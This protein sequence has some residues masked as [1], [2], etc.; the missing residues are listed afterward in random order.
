MLF[1]IGLIFFQQS[2]QVYL[3]KSY[4]HTGI[5]FTVNEELVSPI[6]VI[7]NFDDYKFVDIGWG[8]EEFYQHPNPD[9]LLG[10]QAILVPTSSVIRI[11]GKNSSIDRIIE[12]SDFCIRFDLNNEQFTKLC[13]YIN[14]AFEKDENENRIV[15]LTKSNGRITFYKSHMKYHLFNTC[16]TWVAE[17]LE[18]SGFDISSSNV[19]TAENL[20]EEVSKFGVVLKEEIIEE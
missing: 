3:V 15:S 6:P 20:F 14:N 7:S 2:H 16:N 1:I 13:N 11:E 17:A 5:M 9:Y 12:W 8:D 4:W 19:I 10:A 18:E